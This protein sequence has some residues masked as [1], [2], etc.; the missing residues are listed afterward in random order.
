LA[1]D[2]TSLVIIYCGFV[3]GHRFFQKGP[4]QPAETLKTEVLNTLVLK[5]GNGNTII[6]VE[7]IVQ[8]ASATRYISIHLEHKKF[9]CPG[10]LKSICQHL[11]GRGFI[12]IHKSTVVNS[13]MVLSFKSRRNGDYDLLLN[14]GDVVRLS[15]TYA[16]DFKKHFDPRHRD[17]P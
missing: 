2:I 17:T 1:H 11:D 9:L 14:N 16:R 12:R 10:S 6:Q 5:H 15:R 3:L 7:D 8:I 13:A 4:K